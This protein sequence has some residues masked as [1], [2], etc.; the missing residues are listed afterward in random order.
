MFEQDRKTPPKS[1]KTLWSFA[2][3]LLD[4]DQLK[5]LL[6]TTNASGF[7]VFHETI[8][9]GD[10]KAFNF[11][12]DVH[13]R[14]L[15]KEEIKG[16]IL[17]KFQGNKTLLFKSI[18][19]SLESI[20]MVWDYLQDLLDDDEE[21]LKKFIAHRDDFGDSA[22]SCIGWYNTFPKDLFAPFIAENFTKN[23]A[24]QLYE[25]IEGENL[26]SEL[27]EREISIKSVNNEIEEE[28]KRKK[29]FFNCFC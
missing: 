26:T 15:E 9:S 19:V 8:L 6:L 10:E 27:S 4:K 18:G 29:N 12:L 7:T 16:L 13:E 2:E 20:L 11:I 23:E 25:K 22:F 1:F 24:D 21:T 5:S 3:S 14:I 17:K 28:V